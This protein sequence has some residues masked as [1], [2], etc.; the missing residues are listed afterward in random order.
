MSTNYAGNDA[1]FPATIAIPS[2]GDKRNATTLNTALQPII[3]RTAY[4]SAANTAALVEMQGH[5][6][7]STTTA[8]PIRRLLNAAR[9]T[10]SAGCVTQVR[11]GYR[12]NNDAAHGV[13][14]YYDLNPILIPG[15]T[16]DNVYAIMQPS[17]QGATHEA[18][19]QFMPQVRLTRLK[20]RDDGDSTFNLGDEETLADWRTMNSPFAS[21]TLDMWNGYVLAYGALDG[22]LNHRAPSDSWIYTLT[23]R[24]EGGEH[25]GTYF[26]LM[27]AVVLM[28]SAKGLLNSW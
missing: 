12:V 24:P 4:L 17:D 27:G 21:Y 18:L 8:S 16:I 10:D 13:Y 23:V 2:D 5:F 11:R 25:A 3:D 1:S 20:V 7:A 14:F 26:T 28:R 9:Y 19:P 22:N 15:I 6:E